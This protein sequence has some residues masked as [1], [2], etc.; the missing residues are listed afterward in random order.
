M[1]IWLHWMGV[2]HGSTRGRDTPHEIRALDDR[3]EVCGQFATSDRR[4]VANG[5]FEVPIVSRVPAVSLHVPTVS[6]T[7]KEGSVF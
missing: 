1:A 5:V 6:S 2:Q 4:A 3:L 7:M